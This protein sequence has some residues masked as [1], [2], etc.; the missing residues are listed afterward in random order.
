VWLVERVLSKHRGVEDARVSY[1]SG[2][3]ELRWDPEKAELGQIL[4]QISRLG[5]TPRHLAA[6]A[7]SSSSDLLLRLGVALFGASNVMMLSASLY[8]GW[9]EGMSEAYATLFR[10][11]ILV[12]ATPVALWSAVPFF[13]AAWAGLRNRVLHMDLPISLAIT[14]LYLHGVW[15]TLGGQDTYLDSLTMLVALLL[16]G[17]VLDQRGRRRVA[18]AARSLAAQAPATA[19]RQTPSGVETVLA[20]ALQPGDVL[21]LAAGEEIAADGR[22]SAGEGTVQLALVTGESEPEILRVGDKVVA[23][24]VVIRGSL[25]VQVE[26]VG[27]ETLLAQM[28]AGLSEASERPIRGGIHDQIAPWFTAITLGV[29]VATALVWWLLA[30][31]AAALE[32]TVAVLVVACPCAISLAEPLS[33]AA[34]LGAAARRGLLFRSGDAL[35]CVSE[36]DL[37]ALDKTGTLTHGR[38]VV[39]HASSEVLRVAAGIERGS[40]HP[41]A[42]AIVEEAT[43]RGIPIPAGRRIEEIPGVGVRGWVDGVCWEIRSGKGQGCVEVLGL[44]E[45]RLRD[46]IRKDSSE[47]VG[48]LSALDL[49]LALVTGDRTRTAHR[50]GLEVGIDRI[51]STADPQAKAHWI[52]ARQSEG[53]KVLFVGDGLN[54]GLAL[55]QADVGVA[56]GNGVAS[57]ILVAEAVVATDSLRPLV[58]GVRAARAAR[59][60][61]KWSLRGSL[62]YNSLAVGAAALGYVN[63]LVAAILMPLSS[64]MVVLNALGI[65]RALTSEERSR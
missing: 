2:R 41:I 42:R 21:E 25:E 64:T 56:M 33:L 43:A 23:G 30:G 32:T 38:Q 62:A 57:S 60:A 16:I 48:E 28:A 4:S 46:A 51:V 24:A 11:A 13:G 40:I 59:K 36:V 55:A 1:A 54:D 31:T 19:R 52:C 47:V 22:V 5:Y 37:V 49:E 3:T 34:G 50:I 9:W 6:G 7:E 20:A 26:A 53:H 44:G 35:R 27:E 10:W 29:A 39:V 63:P 18:E 17:R 14:V 45:I 65:E 61:T 58:A 12:I 8:L 15:A